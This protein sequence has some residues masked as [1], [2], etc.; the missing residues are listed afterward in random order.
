M[1]NNGAKVLGVLGSLTIVFGGLI[2][3][4][5]AAAAEPTPRANTFPERFSINA[6]GDLV[7]TGNTL[8]TCPDSK[9][10]C[11]QARTGAGTS[12]AYNNNSYSM[13]MV[14]IDDDPTTIN[15]SSAELAIPRGAPVLFAGL[16]WG[17]GASGNEA[18]GQVPAG[19]GTAALLVPGS[20]AYQPITAST[21][22]TISTSGANKTYSA[23]A[24]ITSIVRAAG[25]GTYTVADVQGSL[26]TNHFAG[27]S[28]IVVYGDPTEPV[29]AMSVFDGLVSVTSGAPA[30]INVSGFKTPPSGP[31]R[32]A[33]G[34][35]AY[36]GD[37]GITGDQF[38]LDG[39]ALGN[40][41]RPTNNFFNSTVTTPTNIIQSKEPN[42]RNQLGFDTGLVDATGR[43]AN[44]AT[45]ATFRAS[46]TGDQ[47]YPAA[48]TFSTELFSPRF[49]AA[50]SVVDIN[51]DAV[52]PGD[53]LEYTLS[54]KNDVSVDNGDASTDTIITDALPSGATY[55]AGSLVIDG[56]S[57][58]DSG[59]VATISDGQLVIRVGDGATAT[60]GGRLAIGANTVITYR[61]AVDADTPGS[62]VLANDFRVAGKAATSGFTVTGVSNEAAVTVVANGADLSI[63]KTAPA[64]LTA[65]QVATYTLVV[66][67]AGPG[68]AESVVISDPLPAG[69]EFI[70]AVGTGWSCTEEVGTV[71][72]DRPALA[73]GASAPPITLTVAVPEAAGPATAVVNTAT[74]AS[75]TPDPNP[76]DNTSTT[77][78]PRAASADLSITKTH[79]G[80]V[81]PGAPITYAIAVRNA[82][83]SVATGITVTDQLPAALS[84]V[85][86]S[87]EDWTCTSAVTC[88][89]TGSLSPGQSAPAI[90]LVADVLATAG[91][92]VANTATVGGNEPDPVPGNNS[93]TDGSTTN[94]VFD[95]I[96]SLSHPGKAVAGGPA[97]P[98]TVRSFN[99][100]PGSVPAGADA[101]QT[102]TLPVGTALESYS[103]AGWTCDPAS[104]S[105]LD[106][107]LTV[108]CTLPLTGDW[109]VDT[110]LTPLVLQV[111][112]AA[113]ETEDKPVEGI[114]TTTS[115]VREIDVANNRATDIITLETSADLALTTSSSATLI[116]GGDAKNLT[117]QVRNLGPAND[118][119]P[120]TVRF[121]RLHDLDVTAAPGSPWTC[122]DSEG[123]LLCV[124]TGVT[125]SAGQFAPA[126]DLAVR[127]AD[128]SAPP[129]TVDLTG[130]VSSPQPDAD[131]ANDAATAP[132]TVVT[133][134]DVWTS[135]SASATTV[136]AGDLVT[137]TLTVSNGAPY[138]GPSV[139]QDV[140]LVDDLGALGLTVEAIEP[141]DAGTDCSAS[142]RL[143]VNCYVG[144]LAVGDA[145]SVR[146]V[147]RTDAAWAD[148]GRTLTNIVTATTSTP[149]GDRPPG[150]VTITT[151]PSSQLTLDK[152]VRGHGD[153]V[154][155]NSGTNVTYALRVGNDG[156]ADAVGA[157]LID[158]L[159]AQITPTVA[160]G[161]GWTCQIVG[162]AVTC[163]TDEILPVG[164]SAPTIFITGFVDPNASGD[165][166]NSATVE[167]ISPGQGAEDDATL[168]VADV[169]DLDIA[170]FGPVTVDAGKT[171]TTTASV[172]NNGPATEPGPIRVVV[173]Q[174][175]ATP[176]TVSGS[177]WD[178]RA[179]KQQVVCLTDGP[180]GLGESLPPIEVRSSTPPTATQANSVA[181][182]TGTVE[183]VDRTNN[184]STTPAILERKADISVSKKAATETVTAGARAT[185]KVTVKNLGPGSTNDAQVVDQL[186]TG[187]TFDR[188]KS[189]PRC[190]DEQ[191]Y[192]QCSTDRTLTAGQSTT[193]TLV[194][195]VDSELR[196][197]VKNSV[198]ATSSQPDPN[199]ANNTAKVTITV[200]P[201]TQ[202]QVPLINP[203]KSIKSQGTTE[204][205]P[206][207]PLTNA[208][209]R[210]KV[211]VT[212][213]PLLERLPRGDFNYCSVT[214]RADGSIWIRTPGTSALSIKISVTAK[215]APGYSS[216]KVV[217]RYT[218][219]KVR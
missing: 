140:A 15:S 99:A 133:Y 194:A 61:M 202:D 60:A 27:W 52:R 29:R 114:L 142:T 101:V 37:L 182:V 82:G 53:L 193:F 120:I 197:A 164:G 212:C 196:G 48:L 180:L 65:G 3:P 74:V 11:A 111:A 85:S 113:G 5:V 39:K 185:Y 21:V 40:A 20:T 130:I 150:T 218:T 146:V 51:G 211:A 132:I 103:G 23:V 184:R 55:V 92:A 98:L 19:A 138:G 35:V 14:D 42:Y 79:E 105:A 203:P 54:L 87:G 90:T 186:P 96:E 80:D 159:P 43:I 144:E 136:E 91:D 63:V 110:S 116:A 139:A 49:D 57:V 213:Q 204:L 56:V 45:S 206:E 161:D 123:R 122:Q 83:P 205:Y 135:K 154:A 137:F 12:S 125:V 172:R 94:R 71:T 156:P 13:V 124:L 166:V 157:T 177:G 189:D 210:A 32:T 69:L 160:V 168:R 95:G 207:Q 66:R 147:A 208:G 181:N 72:C 195:R 4:S 169:V 8:M 187:L 64:I 178:C 34:V 104:G 183:D 129:T 31:V 217:Y 107:P 199:P 148:A 38:S 6:A 78:T 128:P 143:V 109:L 77:S 201:P 145:A 174:T 191:G 102:I 50:K 179:Q 163:R 108:T 173:A 100:G 58:S 59:S 152:T 17:S 117:F 214:T 67:N 115:D 18:R 216:M 44:N 175:S 155:W 198:T 134:A 41:V 93:S 131:P 28:L 86:A 192:V 112:V 16:Y 158:T 127:A 68:S 119:G 22:S 209:Q 81:V 26:G 190:T 10:G 76:G 62:T 219:S 97:L 70:D 215:A 2:S 200:T 153:D 106:S 84:F 188:A 7:V 162:Q 167:P 30:T 75:D 170:H 176:Q 1:R 118:P 33:L 121:S 24:D 36:E 141:M 9:S 126:L 46:S 25:R 171:W 47:Y 149:T 88:V 89:F 165:V 73:A 151:N